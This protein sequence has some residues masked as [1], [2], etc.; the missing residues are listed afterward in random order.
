MIDRTMRRTLFLVLC[1]FIDLGYVRV[2]YGQQVV[3]QV[4]EPLSTVTSDVV[5]QDD[6]D[7]DLTEE[8]DGT[9]TPSLVDENLQST[10]AL[11]SFWDALV[12]QMAS[13]GSADG[14]TALT[15]PMENLTS[16]T[17]S[18][19]T[20]FDEDTVFTSPLE[21][22]T[23]NT[24]S[25]LTDFDEDTALTSPL[26]N[27]TSSTQSMLTDFEWTSVS[28]ST[29]VVPEIKSHDSYKEYESSFSCGK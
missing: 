3:K 19:L 9:V 12:S 8:T 28:S 2:V 23:S 1:L 25:M 27:P 20:D 22:P 4:T 15:S 10:P 11:M 7:Y 21:N 17:Q 5:S 29:T 24:Q 14:D 6:F 26:E 18:M 13:L 16:S